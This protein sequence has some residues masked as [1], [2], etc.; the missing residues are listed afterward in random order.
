MIYLAQGGYLLL[1]LLIPLMF[2]AYWLMRRLR[3]RRIARFG[4]PELVARLTPEVPRRKGWM[5][6]TLLSIAL[7][8]LAIGMARPQL[9]AILKE[10]EIKG[11][12]I[13]VVLDVSNSML[14]E[15]YS[16]NR[17]E[18]AKLAISKLVD[19]LQGDRIGLIIFAGESF[20][21]L[22]IT[23]DY[24][25]AKIFLNSITTESV[26]VQGTAL[27]EAIRTAI[28]GFT[29]ESE[30]SRAIILITDGENH[31]DDPV[32][33]ARDA[34]DMGARVFCIGV[35]SPEGKPIPMDGDLLKDKDGNIVVT[36]LDEQT[37]RDIASAG[38]GLYVRAGNTEFGL[39]PVIDE[40]RTLQDKEFQSVVFEEFDEQYMY[41]F[42]I[43][44]VFLLLEFFMSDT[45][46]RRSLFGRSGKTLAVL[47]AVM[48]LSPA[49]LSAQSDRSEV[50]AGNR[51]FKKGMYREAEIDYKRALIA[52]S[53][54][55]TAKYNLGN[56]LYKAES[57]NE[58]ELYFKDLGDTL[59]NLS[60]SKASDYFHNSGNLALKQKKYQ[61]AV[62]AFKESLRLEPDNFE[63][64][65]NLAYAQ[66]MLR[67]QQQNQQS[68]NQQ[69]QQQDQNQ[70]QNQQNQDQ[71]QNNDQQNDQ[72][73]DQNQNNDQNQDQQNQDQQQQ[74]QAQPQISP[75][76]AQQM[77]QAIEDKEKQTQDKVKKAK[78][79]KEKSKEKEKNW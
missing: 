53:A 61:E 56:A 20:V 35:G 78:A 67:D 2:T 79:L 8:F 38:E 66:K 68:Q 55:V 13:M 27:G 1:I 22:P 45:R 54:S 18:R 59:K 31:E 37:L 47:A 12:E 70:D 10:K 24:V 11:A 7:L 32:A 28:R 51:D 9:G 71:N 15:D 41:F 44:L 23:S 14:A 3:K 75:Q 33:A 39:N 73:Q 34:V 16:P 30:H 4:D 58:A 65:S 6:L 42:A 29:S 64:K 40:I 43:A 63:T 76:A 36:R 49:V 5:K 77:L 57:Y 17:L 74:P 52:D 72:N 26:P 50:R 62:E 69:Q 46:N 19:E 60:P 48:V 21:Q 25:S